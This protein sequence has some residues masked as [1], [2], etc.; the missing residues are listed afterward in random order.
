MIGILAGGVDSRH[1]YATE[2]F[3]KIYSRVEGNTSCI[4]DCLK[5]VKNRMPGYDICNIE[6]VIQILTKNEK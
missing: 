3:T 6:L 1:N 4:R 5:T 2:I